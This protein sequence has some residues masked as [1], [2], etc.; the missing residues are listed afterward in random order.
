MTNP[1]PPG[2]WQG[3]PPPPPPPQWAG[4][5]GQPAPPAQWG[6][7]PGGAPY[8]RPPKK[9]SLVQRPW[10][11]IL[12]AVIALV[13]IVSALSGSDD[14]TSSP[15]SARQPSAAAPAD[16]GAKDTGGDEPTAKLPI[17][18]GDWRLD[19]ITVKDSG[20]GT[21]GGRAR[22]TY[23]GDDDNGGNNIFTVTVFVKGRDVA[24]MQGSASDVR[25]GKT[26]TVDLISSDTFVKGPYRYDFQ[27]DL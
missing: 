26:V 6:G 27:N 12:C 17:Q 7:Q 2:T 1:T 4:Q 23:T 9:K 3:Q 14:T 20:L 13:A 5:P 21:F 19:S 8:G 16:D 25:P 22:V 24:S 18:D 10:F 11:M 15:G